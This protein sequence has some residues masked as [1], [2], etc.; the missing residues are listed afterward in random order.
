MAKSDKELAT[1]GSE[2]KDVDKKKD[3]GSK[4]GNVIVRFFRELKNE[5]KK[6]TWTPVKRTFAN[7]G[8]VLAM[9]VIIGAFVFGLDTGLVELLSLFMNIA[10]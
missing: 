1:K 2:S 9:I 8:I 6:I 3:K 4:K 10:R 5:I 7:M